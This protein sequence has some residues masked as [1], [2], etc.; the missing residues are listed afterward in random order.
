MSNNHTKCIDHRVLPS[1]ADAVRQYQQQGGHLTDPYNV[2]KDPLEGDTSK[3]RVRQE[4]FS[5]KYPSFLEI[6][7]KLVN[8]DSST[9]RHALSFYIDITRRIS[10]SV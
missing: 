5:D 1:V 9:F 3:S 6:F 7:S 10:S 8:G 2:G 4:A